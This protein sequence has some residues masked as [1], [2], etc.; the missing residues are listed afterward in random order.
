MPS[1]G[2]CRATPT[3][4]IVTAVVSAVTGADAPDLHVADEIVAVN[5]TTVDSACAL[6]AAMHA[7]PSGTT[8]TLTIKRARISTSGA[9]LVSGARQR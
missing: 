8:V 2:R 5:G 9:Y 1:A 3:G 6:I 4:A 7:V